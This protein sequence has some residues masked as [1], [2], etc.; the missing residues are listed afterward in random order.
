MIA[1]ATGSRTARLN[2]PASRRCGSRHF[3]LVLQR[4]LGV[5]LDAQLCED[6]FDFSVQLVELGE[7]IVLAP[8]ELA[9]QVAGAAFDIHRRRHS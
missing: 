5:D 6:G 8:L 4:N 9:E 2:R 7:H 3:R 1:A